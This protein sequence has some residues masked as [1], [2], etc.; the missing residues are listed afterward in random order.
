MIISE[1]NHSAMTQF[2]IWKFKNAKTCCHVNNFFDDFLIIVFMVKYTHIVDDIT[3]VS[4]Q[5]DKKASKMLLQ[6]K[7]LNISL[8]ILNL[9]Q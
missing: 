3:S 4:H 9:T 2:I 6:Q 7:N 1:I 5:V 8:Q